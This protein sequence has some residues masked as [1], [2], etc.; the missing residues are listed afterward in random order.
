MKMASSTISDLPS[1]D[2]EIFIPASV[3]VL[4]DQI[5]LG[6]VLHI[7]LRRIN[8]GHFLIVAARSIILVIFVPAATF[9][10][11]AVHALGSPTSTRLFSYFTLTY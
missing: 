4:E 6:I 1:F 5:S 9:L 11:M 3:A 7:L 8:L 10:I 2:D